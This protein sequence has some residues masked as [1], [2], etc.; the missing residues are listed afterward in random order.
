M[1]KSREGNPRNYSFL[2]A[3]LLITIAAESLS[4]QTV[5]SASG[6]AS[7]SSPS[8]PSNAPTASF[9]DGAAAAPP[10]SAAPAGSATGATTPAPVGGSTGMQV[11]D[12]FR[13]IRLGMTISEVEAALK[14]DPYF[15][16]QGPP[17]VSML[18]NPDE[19][20][21]ET[22]G[23][24]F[25]SRAFFQFH[26]KKLYTMILMLNPNE[27]SYYTM[28]TTLVAKYG[29]PSSLSPEEVVWESA[30]H[31]LSLERP[32]SVKYIDRSV[33]NRLKEA[34]KMKQTERSNSRDQF[35]NQF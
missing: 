35:L 27:I 9:S 10:G 34:G 7:P 18:S 29:E 32:L 3:T 33:F 4:A 25:I 2:I 15:D 22:N 13:E 23:Y 5:P 19:N 6:G 1:M 8:N 26:E 14:K 30:D 16:Y 12:S 20:L 24:S 11:P 21:I 17:D 31:R 28:Y